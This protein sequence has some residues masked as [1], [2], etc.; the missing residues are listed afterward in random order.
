MI[1]WD[2]ASKA[3]PEGR[4]K[5]GPWPDKT[6]WSDEYLMTSGACFTHIRSYSKDEAR[7]Y[8]LSEIITIMDRD[9]VSFDKI[10][11]QMY[12]SKMIEYFNSLPEGETQ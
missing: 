4:F 8:L 5:V 6:G 10:K 9:N 11:E 3:H 12:E 7:L 1:A 2:V